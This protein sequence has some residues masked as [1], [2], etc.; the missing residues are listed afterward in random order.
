MSKHPLIAIYEKI[1]EELC[2]HSGC[3][4]RISNPYDSEEIKSA[5]AIGFHIGLHWVQREIVEMLG[6][7]NLIILLYEWEKEMR[8]AAE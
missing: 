3:R 7:E 1:Q 2:S 5:E 6:R 8:N 4:Q